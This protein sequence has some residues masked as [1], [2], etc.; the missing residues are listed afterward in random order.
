MFKFFRKKKVETPDEMA[1]IIAIRKAEIQ[2]LNEQLDYVALQIRTTTD[3]RVAHAEQVFKLFYESRTNSSYY[4]FK[5]ENPAI[6]D[7]AISAVIRGLET[8]LV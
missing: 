5:K 6:C 4:K 7:I 3:L 8:Q 2:A 1:K